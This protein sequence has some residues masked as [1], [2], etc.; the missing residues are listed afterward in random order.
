[1][2]TLEEL[3][4]ELEEAKEEKN[5]KSIEFYAAVDKVNGLEQF[6][7]AKIE[8]KELKELGDAIANWPAGTVLLN[9]NCFFKTNTNDYDL[10]CI[11][12][13]DKI[14]TEY[15][16]HYT[17]NYVLFQKRGKDIKV[18]IETKGYICRKSQIYFFELPKASDRDIK[19]VRNYL[20]KYNKLL[21]GK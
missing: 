11:T 15:S 4:K 1:M 19:L 12:S 10:I 9:K 5:K 20:I 17:I 6:M 18:S 3:Q 16:L 2:K 8:E 7:Q 14:E 13:V 21:G